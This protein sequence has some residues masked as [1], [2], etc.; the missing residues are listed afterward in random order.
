VTLINFTSKNKRKLLGLL[1]IAAT[2]IVPFI[3]AAFDSGNIEAKQSLCP[4]KMLTGLPCPSCGIT[5]SW[6]FLYRG[7]IYKSLY[8]HLFGIPMFALAILLAI[9]LILE[10]IYQRSFF[11]NFLSNNILIWSLAISMIIYHI[12]R[13]TIFLYNN[14]IDDIIKQSVWK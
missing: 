2:L 14:S 12:V 7:N 5:K 4:L 9:K 1:L 8:F 3:I 11:K 13:L 10:I 6:M